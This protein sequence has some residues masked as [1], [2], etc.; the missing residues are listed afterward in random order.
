M[1]LLV[2]ACVVF[3]YLYL[4]LPNVRTLTETT[5]Q[6]PLQIYTKQGDLIAEFG[7]IHRVPVSIHEVPSKLIDAIIVTEDQR[8]YE[9]NG[10]DVVG[11]LRATNVLLST[12][13]KRQG[14]STITMQVA[15]N[16]FLGRE[17]TY[18]R[19][20]N[21]IILA[22]AIE[23]NL[24][25]QQILELYINKIYLGH[26][27][28]GVGAAARNYFGKTVDE[29]TTAEMAMIAGL[30]KAPSTNNPI[31][32][33]KKAIARRN[34]ILGKMLE[35]H[36]INQEEYNEAVNES[37]TIAK[38]RYDHI[39]AGH[40]AE[41]VR[42]TMIEHFGDK[43][44]QE[45]FKVYTTVDSQ[46]QQA[47]Q[48]AI[49]EGLESYEKRQ[50]LKLGYENLE[51]LYGKNIEAWTKHLRNIPHSPT[52]LEAGMVLAVEKDGLWVLRGNQEKVFVFLKDHCW[53][54]KQCKKEKATFDAGKLGWVLGDVVMVRNQDFSWVLGQLPSVQSALV[55]LDVHTGNI[56]ALVGGYQFQRSHFNRAIQA[57]RQPGS[58]IKP[59]L[60][61][62]A[63]ENGYTMASIVN[64][65][66]VIIEDM[67]GE[68]AY[69]RPKNVD[70][71][72]KG[73]IRLRQALIQSRNL[74][75]VRLVKN[76]GIKKALEYFDHFGF[77]AQHQ[78]DS[79][80]LSL[81]SGLTTPLQMAR[82][83]AGFAN[84][85]ELNP[86]HFIDRIE[87]THHTQPISAEE[88]LEIERKALPIETTP[89]Q[90]AVTPETAYIVADALHDVVEQGTG[91]GAKVLGRHDLYGKTGTTNGH[92]DAWFSGFNGDKSAVVWVGYDEQAS[93]KEYAAKLALPI[94]V[95]FM[96]N[97][98]SKKEVQIQRPE[99]VISVL[100]DKKTGLLADSNDK[101]TM[102]EIF[103][104][105]TQP[106]HSEKIKK[107]GHSAEIR[108]DLF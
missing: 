75:T 101:D 99:D 47:A 97:T 8:F 45:G 28:Y 48:V 108:D 36:V 107:A 61:A 62:M 37:V 80:S 64:D 92:A 67:H 38:K 21:E 53:I 3:T 4:H 52:G 41:F 79:L 50:G 77:N 88:I 57:Y 82:A 10:I 74:V 68:N 83:F 13:Q 49:A 73:P 69:W 60:Y 65:A 44:Y 100:I 94:W 42:A 89:A 63:I 35:K 54:N 12:R 84:H 16:F 102:F 95:D 5:Y 78:V 86:V 11:L 20:I 7:S 81:G 72:F 76:L 104:T 31:G 59:F 33:P 19:K 15:R 56:E 91:R 71:K 14:A 23:R 93:L 1:Q 85:G 24:T 106:N 34:F 25:K 105:E 40:I 9:H 70:S 18:F 2:A 98:L 17:K 66:P 43:A 55:S 103:T 27:A 22:L 90:Q 96:K 32:N 29:L 51:T 87:S 39:E 6:E 46:Q 58:V 30:P 26:R